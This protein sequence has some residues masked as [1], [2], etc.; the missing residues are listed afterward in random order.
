M[1]HTFQCLGVNIAVD[2]NSGAVHVLDELT[3]HLLEQV[4]PPMGEHCPAELCARLPQYDPAALEE[5]W[6]ELRGLAAEGL[7]FEEDD[8]IDREKAA[9]MQQ[10]ALVKA[11]CLH[12]SHDCNL[13]CKYC[14]ASTGD[15]GTGHRMTMDFETAKRAI[16]FVI[17][18]SGHRRNI[19]VD[20]FGGTTSASALQLQLMVCSSMMRTS[21]T[22]T[23]RCPTQFSPST[24]ERR[25]TMTS[26]P[27]STAR[28]AMT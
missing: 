3:Y 22:S 23:V 11:L 5:S 7:L 25:S 26:G 15:F 12:V 13:R 17:A 1:V 2:V 28:A 14:F 9:S 21:S 4:Q 8:Y 16:D 24:G 18:K 10:Q 27:R 6:Q 19:E 20:F